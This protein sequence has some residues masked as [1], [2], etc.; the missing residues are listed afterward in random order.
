VAGNSRAESLRHV[1]ELTG[2]GL[3]AT[4]FLDPTQGARRRRAA[5]G[6]VAGARGE[7]EAAEPGPPA[8]VAVSAP[9]TVLEPEP[10]EVSPPQPEPSEELVLLDGEQLG[11]SAATREEAQWPGWGWPLVVTITVCALAA[12][13]AIGLGIWA[14]KE[15]N[16]T[17]TTRTVV[18][19]DASAAPVLADPV[20]RRIIGTA[21]QGNVLLRTDEA[22][23]ALAVDGLPPLAP[24][25]RYRVWVTASGQT[26][27]A[28]SFAGRRAVIALKPLASGSRVTVTRER[29][30]APPGA[31]H[32]PQVAAAAV[33]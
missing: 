14:I 7:R 4:Y 28:G 1:V 18:R 12:F 3:A 26:T 6:W 2:L 10:E 21:A 9:A 33:P 8:T 31:P 23:A 13:A 17:T 19:R 20:A 22:G 15:R 27:R 16:P 25:S 32:G 29:S 30:T 11:L 24:G 5:W